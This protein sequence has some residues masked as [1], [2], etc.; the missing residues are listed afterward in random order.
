NVR[1]F[2]R[3]KLGFLTRS[4]AQYG[5]VVRLEL[6]A[7]TYLLTNPD[8]IR[9]VLLTS[10]DNYLKTPRV[11]GTRGRRFFGAGGVTAAGAEHLRLRR[12]L[13]PLFHR[14]VVE[15]FADVMASAVA[16][17]L[18]GWRD[19]SE[20]DVHAE[21]LALTQRIIGRILFGDEPEPDVARFERA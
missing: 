19:G 13:Q 18:D 9:H 10:Y 3:D 6:G 5:D 2:L 11:V 12:L 16:D 21:L 20:I 1:A 15:R 14:S 7:R 17:M 8:D 4:A